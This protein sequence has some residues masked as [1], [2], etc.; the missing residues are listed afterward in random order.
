MRNPALALLIIASIISNL[1]CA[2]PITRTN[3]HNGKSN[4]KA[5]L[6]NQQGQQEPEC[7]QS[8]SMFGGWQRVCR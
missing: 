3:S 6:Q 1:A 2:A 5:T 8:H 7:Y 4:H